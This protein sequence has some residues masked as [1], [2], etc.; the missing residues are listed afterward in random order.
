MRRRGFTLIEMMMVILIIGVAT[1]LVLTSFKAFQ[2]SGDLHRTVALVAR[3]FRVISA[4]TIEARRP[5]KVA[6]AQGGLTGTASAAAAD[7][8]GTAAF[9]GASTR[10]SPPAGTAIVVSTSTG[11][12][13]ALNAVKGACVID[14]GGA[15]FRD[16]TSSAAAPATLV[17]QVSNPAGCVQ[18]G[19]DPV[20]GVKIGSCEVGP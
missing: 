16:P 15:I 19:M 7:G 17:V 5:Y 13:A 3:L 4:E 18:I 9:T 11:P 1:S 14:V 6:V 12:G 2:R 10:I 8:S 20:A